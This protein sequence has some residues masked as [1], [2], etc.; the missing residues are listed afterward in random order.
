MSMQNK[1]TNIAYIQKEHFFS[2]LQMQIVLFSVLA[3]M[4]DIVLFNLFI[5]IYVKLPRAQATL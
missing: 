1:Q 4:T 3:R 5:T 2:N